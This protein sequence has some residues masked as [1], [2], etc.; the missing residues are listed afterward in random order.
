MKYKHILIFSFLSMFLTTESMAQCT[1]QAGAGKFCGNTGGSTGIPGFVPLTPSVFAPIIAH[2]VIANPTNATAAPSATGQPI[3]SS[4]TSLTGRFEGSSTPLP[5]TAA[6]TGVELGNNG[7]FN[8]IQTAVRPSFAYGSQDFQIFSGKSL[9]FNTGGANNHGSIDQ[10]GQ[11]SITTDP[12]GVYSGFY[13]TQPSPTGNTA[14]S[15][16]TL[17]LVYCLDTISI[18]QTTPESIAFPTV[19]VAT[20]ASTTSG[21]VLHFANAASIVVGTYVSDQTLNSAIPLNTYVLSKAGNDVTLTQSVTGTVASGHNILFVTPGYFVNGPTIVHQ[22]GGSN[23]TG[24]RQSFYVYSLL[25][26]ATNFGNGN[27]QYIG[28]VFNSQAS[29]SDGGTGPAL[30]D[31]KGGIFPLNTIAALNAGATNFQELGIEFDVSARA[32]SSVFYKNGVSIVS[33]A[34]DAV[35]GSGYDAALSISSQSS[36]SIG[37]ANGILFSA[38]NNGHAVGADGCLM[39][40]KDAWTVAKGIDFSSYTIT[41]NFLRGP[42]GNFTVTGAGNMGMAGSLS[43]LGSSSGSVTISAQAA[44]G[45]ASLTWPTGNGTLASSA[46]SPIVLNAINGVISCSTCLTNNQTITL[47]GDATGSGTTTIPVTLVSVASA[48]TTGSSTAI[49]VITINAKGL[50]TAIT[51]AA[52]IAPAGTLTGTTLASNVVTSSLTSLGTITSLNVTTINAFTLGGTISGGGNQINNVIIGSTTPLA[53]NFTTLLISTS[54]TVPLVIG[55][56]GAASTL[57]LE[58]TSGAGTADAIIGKTASQVERFRITTAGLFNIG[59]AIAPDALLTINANTGA[60]VA[61]L[62]GSNLHLLGAD[63]VVNAIDMNVY[64]ANGGNALRAFSVGGTQASKTA[65]VSDNVLISIQGFGWNTSS[66]VQAGQFQITAR[67]TFSAS[68]QG[69]SVGIFTTPL[70]TTAIAESTRFQPSGGVSIGGTTDPLIGGLFLNGQMFMPNITSQ[71]TAASGSICWTT[72]T[73]KFTVDTTLACL[74]SSARFKDIIG[75]IPGATSLDIVNR[76]QTVSF[77]RKK[78]FGG[79]IDPAEQFGFTAEQAA[80]VDER[81]ISRGPDGQPLGVRYMEFTSILAGA[82]QQL[83]A[84][85]DNFETRLAKLENRK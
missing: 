61:P 48:G 17:N 54:E 5:F 71:S 27:N 2:T 8:F 74:T 77:T 68:A 20:N 56:T 19:T 34:D 4:V 84:D 3:T 57:T 75:E 78:E 23:I 65:T 24:G 47:S 13:F 6:N 82:V 31:A 21:A 51:T 46:T 7:T 45:A 16:C 14:T 42:A 33:L 15:N 1:G 25:N 38:A 62:T 60:S 30:A 32:G 26:G 85:N 67:E 28:A 72:G 9:I 58:S 22:Y 36:S 35:R 83:K 64:G 11:F 43:M 29:T 70:T 73:G 18:G 52:V 69:T 53:G 40:T 49:P 41:G 66:Y 44:A 55:G 37:W 63:T 10:N 76:L 59:P 50:T 39:C 80:S 79:D 12:G 81:L